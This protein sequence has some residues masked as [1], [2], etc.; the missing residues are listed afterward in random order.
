MDPAV[1]A[2][3][4]RPAH[5]R[6]VRG[7][8]VDRRRLRPGRPRRPCG[9]LPDRPALH[10]EQQPVEG[11]PL[12]DAHVAAFRAALAETGIVDPVAHN[13]YLINLAQ[14]RRR[15]LEEVDR[16]D[17]RRGRAVRGAGDRRPGRST[18]ARTSGGRGGRAGAD[19]RGARRGPPP[20]RGAAASRS[21][22]RRPP[23]RGPAW[24]TGSSTSGAI[25]DR[26]AEP[27]RLGVCVDTCH[28]F[29]AGYPL[30]TAGGVR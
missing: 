5:A 14:P 4:D 3:P 15:P 13:S 29:A 20:D 1:R 21:T 8:H 17:D 24:G 2:R 18:P 28:I 22:W 27:E 10:Q 25:L 7:P 30:G 12:T 23:G 26:V 11:A 19:R 9:R 16:R 6:E